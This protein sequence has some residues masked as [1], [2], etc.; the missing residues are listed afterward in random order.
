VEDFATKAQR[1]K[2]T[3][4]GGFCHEGT[5]TERNT[6]WRI[7]PRR[8]KDRKK[9][10]VE[11]FATKAQRHEGTQSGGICYKDTKTQRNAKKR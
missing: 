6:K 5:K 8:H 11:E 9:H 10:K 2:E 4:S 7:L 1:Q 3:Q